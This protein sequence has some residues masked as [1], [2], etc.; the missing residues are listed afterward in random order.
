MLAQL[1]SGLG[2]TQ[3]LNRLSLQAVVN[4]LGTVGWGIIGALSSDRVKSRTI[5]PAHGLT[6]V[7]ELISVPDPVDGAL[8][9]HVRVRF[10]IKAIMTPNTIMDRRPKW[11]FSTM[12][13]SWNCKFLLPYTPLRL[14]VS[15]KLKVDSCVGQCCNKL[16]FFKSRHFRVIFVQIFH[17]YHVIRQGSIPG[18]R[19]RDEFLHLG[20]TM[21]KCNRLNLYPK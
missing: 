11:S 7:K 19:Y 1:D 16:H 18:I 4:D 21:G 20:E 13:C 6:R 2:S 15:C 3:A 10:S 5:T 9:Y 17:P 14:S 12:F 8:W